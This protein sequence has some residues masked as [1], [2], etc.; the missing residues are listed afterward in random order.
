MT[1]AG[2]QPDQPSDLNP[3]VLAK[4]IIRCFCV[5]IAF[6]HTRHH[7][8]FRACALILGAFSLVFAAL[9]G[10]LL[11][12][13]SIPRTLKTVFNN[14]G[15]RD[16]FSIQVICQFCYRVFPLDNLSGDSQC[17]DCRK[18]LFRPDNR[19]YLNRLFYC[20][21]SEDGT[22]AGETPKGIPYLVA[23]VQ[24]P[25]EGLKEFFKCPGMLDA[26]EEWKTQPDTP[27]ELR[28][29][30]DG[31]VWKTIPDRDGK[32]FFSKSPT[33]GEIRLGVTF[34]LDWFVL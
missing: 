22:D 20:E 16:G 3:L 31:R 33:P 4:A 28:S 29:M 13:Q 10:N 25:S 30:Q 8:S 34:S 18:A 26:V 32:P 6:L 12:G 21:L 27:G 2:P 9:P 11:Q 19:G 7:V 14:L 23:P 17:P 15:I 24:L 1:T 5:L